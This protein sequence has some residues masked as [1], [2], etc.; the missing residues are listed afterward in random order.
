MKMLIFNKKK[1]LAKLFERSTIVNPMHLL[2]KNNA[3]AE[4]TVRVLTGPIMDMS[5]FGHR[6]RFWLDGKR[7]VGCN[8]IGKD[9]KWGFFTV[10]KDWGASFTTIDYSDERN[11]LTKIVVDQV[12]VTDY[13]NLLI[14][15]FC[16]KIFGKT[17]FVGYFTLR[18]RGDRRRAK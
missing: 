14:G 6:K 7:V 17:R 15:R 9:C 1:K 12:R 3:E 10:D 5:V 16:L 13:A 2:G 18:R 4:W 11:R 8:V